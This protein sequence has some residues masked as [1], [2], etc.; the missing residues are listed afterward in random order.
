MKDR[1]EFIQKMIDR[2]TKDFR[3]ICHSDHKNSPQEQY[4]KAQREVLFNRLW[5][6]EDALNNA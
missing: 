3:K 2:N 1:K 4:L 5:K 6:I